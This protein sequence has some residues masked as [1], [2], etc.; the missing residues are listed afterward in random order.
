MIK[1]I[2]TLGKATYSAR[3]LSFQ[4]YCERQRTFGSSKEQGCLLKWW[5]RTYRKPGWWAPKK[6]KYI[7]GRAVHGLCEEIAR[8]KWDPA[9]WH[10]SEWVWG[11]YI[12]IFIWISEKETIK[13]LLPQ[14]PTLPICLETTGS[15]CPR[16]WYL[17]VLRKGFYQLLSPLRLTSRVQ[18][19]RCLNGEILY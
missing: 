8:K 14:R 18:S 10:L 12:Y 11:S 19:Q 15:S 9:N 13:S 4:A 17:S 16:W 6:T 7:K 2:I 3:N 5:F 1:S